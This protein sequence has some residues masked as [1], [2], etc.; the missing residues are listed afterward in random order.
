MDESA[1]SP[2]EPERWLPVGGWEG[3]YEVSDLGRVRSVPRVVRRRGVDVRLHGRIL[4]LQEPSKASPYFTVEL[5]R[6]GRRRRPKVHILVAAAFLGPRP[7]KHDVCHGPGRHL[8]NRVVNLSYGTHAKNTGPDRR[9]DGG[10][11]GWSNIGS[12]N[13]HAKLNDEIVA[14]CRIRAAAG[15]S[16]PSLAHEFGITATVMRK[17]VNGKTWRHV[18]QPVP[19]AVGR[20]AIPP[21]GNWYGVRIIVPIRPERPAVA[22]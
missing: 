22:A 2:A 4:R 7:E 12:R 6:V 13:G 5:W 19:S 20:H 11:L 18:P 8:D 21:S 10:A 1:T 16:V 3:L 9:R 17:A 15:E 14:E